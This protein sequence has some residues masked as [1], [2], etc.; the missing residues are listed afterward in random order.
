LLPQGLGG[1]PEG[2]ETVKLVKNTDGEP[3]AAVIRRR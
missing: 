1:P 3:I 2:W